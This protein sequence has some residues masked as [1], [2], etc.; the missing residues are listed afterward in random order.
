MAEATLLSTGGGREEPP[1]DAISP[2]SLAAGRA[3]PPR[4]GETPALVVDNGPPVPRQ[5]IA[6]VDPSRLTRCPDRTIGEIWLAGPNVAD[7]YY[8]DP[9]RTAEAFGAVMSGPDAEPGS[10]LRTGDLGYMVDRHVFV[11]GRLKEMMI[12]N[13]RNLYPHDIEDV[14]REHLPQIRDV[15][16]FS[17][18]ENDGSERIVA[19]LELASN[20]R[21]MI[22]QPGA[23]AREALDDLSRRARA[24][25]ARECELPLDHVRLALPGAVLKTTSG[26]TRY[27]GLRSWF[28]ALAE[29]T[30]RASMSVET[31]RFRP[32]E[33]EA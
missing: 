12:V 16:V 27:G 21:R 4:E 32:A 19:V 18:P 31:D 5:R 2:A 25:C 20:H 10:W 7:G 15:A 13:G 1:I 8:N 30:R 26:K 24:V 28:R 29:E 17:V 14:L 6:I 11:T 9:Q 22:L 23:D 33:A 3:E